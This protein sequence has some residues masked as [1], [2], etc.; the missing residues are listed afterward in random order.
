M[1]CADAHSSADGVVEAIG[2]VGVPVSLVSG[3]ASSWVGQKA[4]DSWLLN[5]NTL[6]LCP[7]PSSWPSVP[8]I[9]VLRVHTWSRDDG[10]VHQG[11]NDTRCTISH[12]LREGDHG[13]GSGLAFIEEHIDHLIVHYSS[14]GLRQTMIRH[15]DCL[16]E[17][18]LTSLSHS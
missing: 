14:P 1:T 3:L 17:D 10:W 8:N 2:R 5:S 4:C 6:M 16:R 13:K 18:V 7:S 15:R 12:L 11:S 9:L